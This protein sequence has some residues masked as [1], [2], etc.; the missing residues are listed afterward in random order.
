MA[1]TEVA[2]V[3][4]ARADAAV[5]V[6]MVATAARA[7]SVDFCAATVARAA[8]AL[9]LSSRASPAAMVAAVVRRGNSPS[10]GAMAAVLS[11]VTVAAVAMED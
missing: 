9:T 4:S 10:P 2:R 1:V 5:T 6:P 7:A 11:A 3:D 8:M